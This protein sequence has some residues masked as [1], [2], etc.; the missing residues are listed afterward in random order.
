[1]QD[2]SFGIYGERYVSLRGDIK[3][4]CLHLES[5]VYGEEYDSEKHYTFSK[6]ETDRLFEIVSLDEFIKLCREGYVSGMEAFFNEHGLE[7]ST[8]TF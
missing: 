6:E 3:D 5:Y 8:F 2:Q 4:G 1:M 7:P